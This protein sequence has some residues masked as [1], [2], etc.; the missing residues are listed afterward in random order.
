[1]SVYGIISDTHHFDWSSFAKTDTYGV[2]SRLRMTL[3]ETVRAAEAVRAAGGDTLFHGGD[4]FHVRGKISPSVLNPTLDTYKHIIKTIGVDITINAGNH[5]LQGDSAERLGSAITALEG[6]GCKVINSHTSGAA[7][8]ESVVMVPWFKRIEDLKVAIEYVL[9]SD[10]AGVDLILHAPIDGVIKGLPD[11]GLTPEYL[12]ALGYKR[13]FS[14]HYHNHKKFDGEV[15]SIGAL[16]HLTWSDVGSKAGFLIV[17]QDKVEWHA[18]RAPQFIEIDESTDL[19]DLQLTADGNYIKAK[20]SSDKS[21]DIE[22]MRR[23][24]MEDC[25]A[26]G[27]VIFQQKTTVSKRGG[28]A[29]VSASSTLENSVSSYITSKA[30]PFEADLQRLCQEILTEARAVA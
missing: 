30:L 29:T 20:I 24:L 3:S 6:I 2:N 9:P 7:A 19:D 16:T 22:E 13:V 12:A 5:D 18:S 23:F 28:V 17:T 1:M 8:A 4:L 27:C 14:G 21:G 25:K 15:Y 11:H 10:R 26:A